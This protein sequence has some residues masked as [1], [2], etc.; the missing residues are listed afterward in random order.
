MEELQRFPQ[1]TAEQHRR[2]VHQW[3]HTLGMEGI[4]TEFSPM[5]PRETS[6]TTQSLLI[7]RD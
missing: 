3:Y 6:V 4:R 7:R 1:I 5:D 2:V